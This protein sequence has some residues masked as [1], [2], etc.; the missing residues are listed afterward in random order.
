MCAID[1]EPIAN[2]SRMSRRVALACHGLLNNLAGTHGNIVIDLA[3][4]LSPLA[5]VGLR[6]L[7]VLQTTTDYC[8]YYY[9]DDYYHYYYYC[10]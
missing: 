6:G 4:V 7:P 8:Y 9:Y 2:L 1:S 3:D 10:C 5:L